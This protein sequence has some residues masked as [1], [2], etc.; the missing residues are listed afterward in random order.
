[1][2]VNRRKRLISDCF[3]SGPSLI[4]RYSPK[5][6]TH[7]PN[8]L[9]FSI[10]MKSI[11]KRYLIAGGLVATGVV[12]VL[13]RRNRKQ[14]NQLIWP[15]THAVRRI[16]SPFG[17]RNNPITDEPEFH[18]GIDISSIEGS[19]V[20]APADGRV[21]SLYTNEKGGKQLVISHDNGFV[22]GYA[23][24][25]KYNVKMSDRVFQGQIIAYVGSTGQVTGPHLHFTLKD[26][27]GNYLNPVDYLS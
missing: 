24:L 25:S 11:L 3:G 9:L 19:P 15:L 2:V 17:N 21:T 4:R 7:P 22:T 16:T 26:A 10:V 20:L 27:K 13:F 14:A 23:H 8:Y 5:I 18:N 1:M 6:F 12:A